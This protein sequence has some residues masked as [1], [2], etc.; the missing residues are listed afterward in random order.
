MKKN[1][2]LLLTA[3]LLCGMLFLPACS[4]KK[5]ENDAAGTTAEQTDAP[6]SDA[7]SSSGQQTGPTEQAEENVSSDPTAE[8]RQNESVTGQNNGGSAGKSEDPTKGSEA[9]TL[10]ANEN[11]EPETQEDIV[12]DTSVKTGVSG[13]PEATVSV[14]RSG[15]LHAGDRFTVTFHLHNAVRLVCLSV[16]ME[17]NTV[18]LTAVDA[19]TMG[20][21]DMMESINFTGGPVRYSGLVMRTTDVSDADLFSV[22]FVVNRDVNT[23]VTE[24][25]TEIQQFLIGKDAEGKT[26]QEIKADFPSAALDL[27]LQG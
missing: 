14:D 12:W 15:A 22:T 21:A 8:T 11:N 25:T 27:S 23:T 13:G 2:S 7:D 5:G 10:Q 3:V 20:A 9:E 1:M 19:E 24:I 18:L 17:Y 16:R 6:L 26:T 4:G